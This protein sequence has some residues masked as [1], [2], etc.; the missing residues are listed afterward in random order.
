MCGTPTWSHCRQ[1]FS[2]LMLS[3][4]KAAL[5]PPASRK[6]ACH[7]L[8]CA[9]CWFSCASAC[10]V[11]VDAGGRVGRSGCEL[12]EECGVGV[13]LSGMALSGEGTEVATRAF[14]ALACSAVSAS[15]YNVYPHSLDLASSS[16]DQLSPD[17]LLAIG[18]SLDSQGL[19]GSRLSAE[20]L[21][22][23]SPL[24]ALRV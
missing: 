1:Y 16:L 3:S 10:C 21:P 13:R 6:T 12:V 19:L 11:K 8:R 2:R 14:V 22:E 7:R 20:S 18:A 17:G 15:A 5:I 9:T 4:L 23:R 24:D